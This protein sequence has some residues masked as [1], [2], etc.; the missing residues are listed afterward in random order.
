[1][2]WSKQFYHYDVRLWLYGDPTQPPPPAHGCGGATPGGATSTPTT[3]CRCRT[4]G[5][6]PG[7]RPGTWPSTAS[8]WPTWIP[9][10]AK[11][12]LLLLERE[13]YQHPN[14]PLPAYE[15][16]FDDVNPPV[17][18]WAALRG[19]RHRRPAVTSTS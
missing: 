17:Q 9:S 2:L 15:W 3:S 18:A 19:L 4:S 10:F 6:T 7:S 8:R 12:Q 1:M 13:W 5:S 14:G 11:S 16:A